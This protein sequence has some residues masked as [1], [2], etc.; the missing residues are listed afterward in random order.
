MRSPKN[1][2]LFIGLILLICGTISGQAQSAEEK[3]SESEF[4]ISRQANSSAQ[5]N[6][7]LKKDVFRQ[8]PYQANFEVQV[9]YQDIENY[10][11]QVPYQVSLPYTDIEYYTETEYRC[12]YGSGYRLAHFEGHEYGGHHGGGYAPGYTPGYPQPYPY[13]YPLPQCGWV[14]VNKPR[15]VTRYR[16]ET[17]YHSE[18]RTRT[19]TRYKSETRCCVTRYKDVFDHSYS[20]SVSLKLPPV[21]LFPSEFEKIGISLGG[22]ESAPTF[23]LN[24]TGSIYP[25]VIAKQEVSGASVYLELTAD[26]KFDNKNAGYL[27]VA[28]VEIRTIQGRSHL[29]ISDSVFGP[30][31]LSAYSVRVTDPQHAFLAEG[32]AQSNGT[33]EV[34]IPLDKDL[35]G[36]G[37][38]VIEL[39]VVRTGSF[40]KNG[41]LSFSLFKGFVL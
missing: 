1:K 24:T 6:F 13:P 2:K 41:G 5:I 33:N 16:T 23:A 20:F 8:E 27:S 25:Y 22:T 12:G 35:K 11:E 39:K 26:P 34:W 38:A 15:Y 14:L 36:K 29:R 40:I 17:R 10:T 19:V 4:I 28:T 37:P 7:N 30:H 32:T 3:N 31:A 9:P 21:E 18:A